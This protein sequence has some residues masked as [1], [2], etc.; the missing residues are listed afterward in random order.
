M[1]DYACSFWRVAA[2][3]RPKVILAISKIHPTISLNRA[4]VIWVHAKQ[5]FARRN[6]K[7]RC[8]S[9]QGFSVIG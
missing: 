9:E 4:N 1:R 8:Y 2:M 5:G 6:L 3:L 7:V